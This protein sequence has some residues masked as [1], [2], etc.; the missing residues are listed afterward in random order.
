MMCLET[1]CGELTGI[2][3]KMLL[4]PHSQAVGQSTALLNITSVVLIVEACFIGT[5]DFVVS[6]IVLVSMTL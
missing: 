4:F 3:R 5:V 1:N 2:H 6:N